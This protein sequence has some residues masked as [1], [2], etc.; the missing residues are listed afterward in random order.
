M[1]C[2]VRIILIGLLASCKGETRNGLSDRDKKWIENKIIE[3]YDS[4]TKNKSSSIEKDPS[5][6]PNNLWERKKINIPSSYNVGGL[7][8]YKYYQMESD[9]QTNE[10]DG[11]SIHSA[12]ISSFYPIGWSL[13]G[14]LFAYMYHW[15]L[16]MGSQHSIIIFDAINDKNIGELI[17]YENT[18]NGE[19]TY[20]KPGDKKVDVFLKKYNI[21]K[22]FDYSRGKTFNSRILDK[23]F[24]FDVQAEDQLFEYSE[25]NSGKIELFANVLHP[26]NKRKKITTIQSD[27][28][29]SSFSIDGVIKSPVENRV[30]VLSVMKENGYE[31]EIDTGIL[32]F[33]CNL[34]KEHF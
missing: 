22:H 13:D 15:E 12:N 34:D 25:Y 1:K 31:G 10:D 16:S 14:E 8:E 21:A 27:G 19:F 3:V 23:K 26:S 6:M 30:I 28:N 17:L 32:L 7:K 20:Y 29:L 9:K 4:I 18:P 5:G 2:L 11:F 33:G 24:S